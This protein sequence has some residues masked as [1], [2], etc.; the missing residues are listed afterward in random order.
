MI[1][2]IEWQIN[3]ILTATRLLMNVQFLYVFRCQN[4]LFFLLIFLKVSFAQDYSFINDYMQ[5]IS[6]FMT[7]K[8][9]DGQQYKPFDYKMML[10]NKYM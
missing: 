7:S 8:A 10:D 9:N 2:Y 6:G 1:L 5:F 4:S 3:Y